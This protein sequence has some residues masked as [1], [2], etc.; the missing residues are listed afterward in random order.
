MDDAVPSQVGLIVGRKQRIDTF[1][2]ERPQFGKLPRQGHH[3]RKYQ[4]GCAQEEE[5]A[6]P[7]ERRRLH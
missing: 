6:R 2:D 7:Y 5:G 1:R 4:I 3:E